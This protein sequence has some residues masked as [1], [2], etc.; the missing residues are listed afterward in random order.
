MSKKIGKII[1]WICIILVAFGFLM[2]SYF[3]FV[4]SQE[5]ID[6][7]T[8]LGYGDKQIQLGILQLIVLALYLIPRTSTVGT[9][10]LIG[11]LSGAYAT[12]I[13]HGM[14]PAD[15]LIIPF[16]V[17]ALFIMI[18]AWFRNPELKNRLMTGK[19]A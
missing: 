12:N 13:T 15:P 1:S 2:A 14:S 6:G 18:G 16:Y 8:M 4:P 5:M 9:V 3:K 17:N 11:Y 10:L 7:A 19:A